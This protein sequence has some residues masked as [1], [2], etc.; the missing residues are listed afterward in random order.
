M[1]EI[2]LKL[3]CSAQTLNQIKAAPELNHSKADSRRVVSDYYDTKD[4]FLLQNGYILRVRDIG[5]AFIQTIKT[6]N[7]SQAGLHKR[8][9]W[10]TQVINFFPD[11]QY[12]REILDQS[13]MQQLEKKKLE[14]IFV[15]DFTR[16]AYKIDLPEQTRVELALDEGQ[17]KTT[18]NSS[19]ICEVEIE[20]MLGAEKQ[21]FAYA[22][23]LQAKYQLIP[24]DKSKAER[25]FELMKLVGSK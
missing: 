6:A 25:G 8:Q 12:L 20:L 7:K 17:V 15:T 14:K 4:L 10:E 1:Q 23:Q 24:E 16:T 18:G 9:E 2:E 3:T 22:K 21:L 5:D 11:W 19:P 13:T